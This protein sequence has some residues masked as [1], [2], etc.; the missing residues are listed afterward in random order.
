M[1]IA[2]TKPLA[3]PVAEIE[4]EILD[5]LKNPPKGKWGGG[6]MHA[7]VTAGEATGNADNLFGNFIRHDLTSEQ[8]DA[9]F[10]TVL[11]VCAHNMLQHD[12]QQAKFGWS[13]C[14]TLPQAACGLSSLNID[15]KLA[16]ATALVWIV[17]YRSVMSDR[18]LDFNWKPAPLDGAASLSEALK[19]SP[20]VAAA[21]VWYADPGEYPQVKQ[22]LA[23]QA[24]IR[25][26]QHLIKYTRACFDMISYDPEYERLYLAATAHLCGLWVIERPEAEIRG[27]LFKAKKPS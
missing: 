4:R 9:A 2:G 16:L 13:H 22:T 7:L 3:R 14:L 11:R 27:H 10:R 18:A 5:K 8:I 26:D 19:T 15:R 17:A 25:T 6:G 12:T 24:L 23:T 20:T 21:R 1:A